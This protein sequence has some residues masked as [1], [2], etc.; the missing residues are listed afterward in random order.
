[1]DKD[2]LTQRIGAAV[3]KL[4]EWLRHDL[5]LADKAARERAEETLAAIIAAALSE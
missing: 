1:M 3:A 5:A 2:I 4:P